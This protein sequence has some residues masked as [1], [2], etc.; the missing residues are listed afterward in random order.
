MHQHTTVSP[1]Q[2][3]GQSV[4]VSDC[5]H[6]NSGGTLGDECSAV[7]GAFPGRQHAHR[8]NAGVQRQ[9]GVKLQPMVYRRIVTV[10]TVKGDSCAGKV[11]R[12][13][14]TVQ[15][16]VACHQVCLA[17][18]DAPVF[19]FLDQLPKGFCLTLGVSNII[20]D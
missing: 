13:F 3:T 14:V 11:E 15:Q 7:S 2:A 19:E 8:G 9:Y 4:G 20:R 6:G 12:R 18:G 10:N 1:T 16:A 17:G 5:S